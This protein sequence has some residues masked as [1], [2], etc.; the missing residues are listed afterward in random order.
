MVAD[1]RLEELKGRADAV[2]SEEHQ[3]VA[4]ALLAD[5]DAERLV[6]CL[7]QDADAARLS[8]ATAS[9]PRDDRPRGGG[10]G[11]PQHRKGKGRKRR[12]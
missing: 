7:L 5:P 12:S 1:R 10:P 9:M 3:A 4:R 8:R 2:I 6:S 11:K